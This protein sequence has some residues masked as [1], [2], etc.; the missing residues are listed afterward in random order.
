MSEKLIITVDAH[1]GKPGDVTIQLR[2]DLAPK[3]VEQITSLAKEGIVNIRFGELLRAGWS[4]FM[5]FQKASHRVCLEKL[6][7]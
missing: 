4:L 2:P 6:S 1:D 7:K 5:R 3:H